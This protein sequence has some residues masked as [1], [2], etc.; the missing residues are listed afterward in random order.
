[1]DLFAQLRCK[2]PFFGGEY[3]ECLGL[4]V[5]T[6]LALTQ[7]IPTEPSTLSETTY[8]VHQ[9]GN[10]TRPVSLGS[11]TGGRPARGSVTTEGRRQHNPETA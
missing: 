9:Y 3:T 5:P 6:L 11:R 1:M 10:R 2:I 8:T 7:T 4:S